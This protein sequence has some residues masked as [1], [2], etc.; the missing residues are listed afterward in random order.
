MCLI[1]TPGNECY[2]LVQVSEAADY[3]V[4]LQ[5]AGHT[6]GGQVFPYH[7]L[8]YLDQGYISGLYKKDNTLLYI[9]EGTVG[10]GPRMRLLSQTEYTLVVLRSPEAMAT[11]DSFGTTSGPAHAAV[12]AFVLSL[13]SAIYCFCYPLAKTAC[14]IGSKSTIDSSTIQLQQDS[15]SRLGNEYTG[16][17]GMAVVTETEMIPRRDLSV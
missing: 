4:G 9:T 13:I 5:L 6:H 15:P 2:S 11:T 3:G 17:E 12:A 1:G 14:Q 7:M 16:R 10:W 8:V